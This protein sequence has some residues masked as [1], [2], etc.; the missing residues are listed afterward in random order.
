MTRIDG[1][2]LTGVP[3][4]RGA[5]GARPRA[6]RAGRRGRAR[7]SSC[8]GRSTPIRTPA[9]S[10][11]PPDGKLA[12]LD[13]GCTL[14]LGAGERAAYAR[15]VLAIA[16][17]D[18]AAAAR[19]LAS[20]GFSADD[21]AQLVALTASLIGAMRPGAAVERARLGGRVRRRRSRSA[22]QLGGLTIPRSFVLLGRVL[23]TVAGLLAT[24]QA[25]DP[26]PPADRA[27]PRGG[28]RRVR[29]ALTAG[30][31]VAAA[32][33]GAYSAAVKL[34]RGVL[35]MAASALGFSAMSLLVKV[36]SA[37]LPTGEIVLARA[38]I[39][40]ALSYVM[41]ARARL[42][43]PAPWGT[44]RAGL[45]LR[46]R[47]RLRRAGRVLP[48]DRAPAARRRDDDPERDPADHGAAR[49]VGARRAR[50]RLDGRRAR[51]RD[52]RRAADRAPERRG[53]RSG[54]RR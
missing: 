39:T 36:T 11:S 20:L 38:V 49:V 1:E 3:R 7:R 15:L 37:R 54:G 13:F 12:L 10:W 8:A 26:A 52:R 30:G 27:P 25:A 4:A 44:R 53:A 42:P 43:P 2:R 9:T 5:G 19:E 51:V 17:G 14:E 23:A 46:G 28:G 24:L 47:A 33:A 29:S 22:K 50:R 40:L 48:R 45:V 18:E 35:Y 32:G 16:G 6:R 21:P 31:R 34:S 41:V